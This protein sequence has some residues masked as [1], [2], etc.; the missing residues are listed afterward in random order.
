MACMIVSTD[1]LACPRLKDISS[2]N[3]I[4]GE[5]IPRIFSAAITHA[6]IAIVRDQRWLLTKMVA[7]WIIIQ[8]V[9]RLVVITSEVLVIPHCWV[10]TTEMDCNDSQIA[11]KEMSR[12]VSHILTMIARRDCLLMSKSICSRRRVARGIVMLAA[13]AI[14]PRQIS[15]SLTKTSDVNHNCRASNQTA[16][17]AGSVI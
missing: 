15:V 3:K 4:V 6:V 7:V 12:A 5:R 8:A 1:M 17:M 9:S 11:G 13:N 2:R 16:Q 10:T 14:M